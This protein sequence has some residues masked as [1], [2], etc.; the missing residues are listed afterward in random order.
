M[1]KV[2]FV[3]SAITFSVTAFG[4]SDCGDPSNYGEVTKSEL[5]A[6]VGKKAVTVID[7]NSEES[8]AKNHVPT[9]I[10]FFAV[11]NDIVN[12]LPTDKNTLIVAYCGGVKCN[13]WQKAA[14][15]ACKAGYNNVKHYKGGIKGWMDKS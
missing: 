6:L 4:G 9:A 13:A 11:K 8:F 5:K 10:H 14:K 1:K 3:V 2:L 15:A 7:V 12:A